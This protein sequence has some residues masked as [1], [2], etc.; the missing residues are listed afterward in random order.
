MR[1]QLLLFALYRD[2]TGVSELDV[3]VPDGAT[4]GVALADLRARD[5]RFGRLPERPVIA[6]N[7]EYAL[8]DAPLAD[9]DE[10]ALLPPVAGG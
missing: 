10:L 3:Q 2:L 5:A 8:L 7:R 4:A 9:G 1:I 6:I